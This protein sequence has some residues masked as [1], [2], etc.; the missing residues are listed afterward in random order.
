MVNKGYR[1]DDIG[2]ELGVAP[3]TAHR[4]YNN[5]ESSHENSKHDKQKIAVDRERSV[6]RIKHLLNKNYRWDDIGRDL[7]VAPSTAYRWYNKNN[8]THSSPDNSEIRKNK[9]N[10]KIKSRTRITDSGRRPKNEEVKSIGNK[11]LR[12]ARQTMQ[13]EAGDKQH[14]QFATNRWVYQRLAIDERNSKKEIKQAIWDEKVRTCRICQ[15]KFA[16]LTGLH[17]HRI[18]DSKGY[19]YDNCELLHK[20]C[21]ENIKD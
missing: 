9:D 8:E 14:V 7:G 1:W 2:Q 18:N 4:W 15:I 19:S 10:A 6:K 20:A 12:Y 11:I 5:A 16:T 3:S 13:R 21:H 17:L